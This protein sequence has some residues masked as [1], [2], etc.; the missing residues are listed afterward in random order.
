MPEV[1]VPLMRKVLREFDPTPSGIILPAGKIVK[2]FEGK[3]LAR[4]AWKMV[5]GLHFLHTEEVGL[6]EGSTI[7]FV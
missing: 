5:R 2:R 7:F 6:A 1:Q 4:V 3:R